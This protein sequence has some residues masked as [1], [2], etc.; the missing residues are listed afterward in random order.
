[1]TEEKRV[2]NI[3]W[4]TESAGKYL[5]PGHR[6]FLWREMCSRNNLYENMREVL[7]TAVEYEYENGDETVK[8]IYIQDDFEQVKVRL[9]VLDEDFASWMDENQKEKEYGSIH[10]YINLERTDEEVLQMMKRNHMD[11]NYLMY[12]IP[13]LVCNKKYKERISLKLSDDTYEKLQE[14][15]MRL[16]EDTN[17]C[18]GK[19]LLTLRNYMKKEYLFR[20]IAE[21]YFE[22]GELVFPAHLDVQE[23]DYGCTDM[24]GYGVYIIPFAV[25]RIY[26]S[27]IFDLDEMRNDIVYRLHEVSIGLLN[28][29][30]CGYL[31]NRCSDKEI[32]KLLMD[33]LTTPEIGVMIDDEIIAH[34]K[35]GRYPDIFERRMG[36]LLKNAYKEDDK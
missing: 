35:L 21:R 13:I 24:P 6:N 16:T 25:R 27:P 30:T 29:L 34:K 20:N 2:I 7:F 19:Q 4:Y 31:P 18:V 1:M 32:T 9:I 28:Q 15:L 10:E 14:F 17:V 22:K 11:V 12:G 3:P 23:W 36:R 33:D 26:T 5:Y 8:D